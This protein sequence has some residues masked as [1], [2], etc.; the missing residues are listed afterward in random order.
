M[1]LY[2]KTVTNYAFFKNPAT[3]QNVMLYKSTRTYFSAIVNHL[4]EGHYFN[5]IS[6]D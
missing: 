1:Q 6:S 4:I 3:Q 2:L 5:D